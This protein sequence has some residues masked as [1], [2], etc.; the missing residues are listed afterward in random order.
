MIFFLF[1]FYMN[2]LFVVTLSL[3]PDAKYTSV[4]VLL[5]SVY[6]VKLSEFFGLFIVRCLTYILSFLSQ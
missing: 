4:F 2:I 1:S 3:V 5:D 6:V